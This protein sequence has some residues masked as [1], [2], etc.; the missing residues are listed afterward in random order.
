M[1]LVAAKA[2]T[3]FTNGIIILQ[4]VGSVENKYN[5]YYHIMQEK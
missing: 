1:V 5:I 4:I 2:P 3:A